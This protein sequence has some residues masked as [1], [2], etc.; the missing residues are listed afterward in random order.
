MEMDPPKSQKMDGTGSSARPGSVKAAW[1]EPSPNSST[2]TDLSA[3]FQLAQAELKIQRQA[4]LL[5]M[6]ER[7][8]EEAMVHQQQALRALK[9]G[10]HEGQPAGTSVKTFAKD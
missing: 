3:P 4:A 8:F 7:K 9:I 2:P 1:Q 6:W 10:F 5:Q